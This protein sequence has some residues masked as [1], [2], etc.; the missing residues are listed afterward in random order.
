MYKYVMGCEDRGSAML[1]SDLFR[2]VMFLF[3][4]GF[5]SEESEKID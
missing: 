4:S 5:V 2:G 1:C 3:C